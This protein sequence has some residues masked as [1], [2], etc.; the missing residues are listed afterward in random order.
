MT[1]IADI[2]RLTEEQIAHYRAEG[3]L[4]LDRLIDPDEIAWVRE[5]YDRLFAQRTGWEQGDQ[6][7]LA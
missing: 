7:D 1:S 5:I 4:Q 6:F 2:P 3:Y